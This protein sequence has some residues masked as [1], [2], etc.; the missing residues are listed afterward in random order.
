MKWA[1]RNDEHIPIRLRPSWQAERD[2]PWGALV[3]IAV[4]FLMVLAMFWI[5]ENAR[6]LGAWFERI[7]EAL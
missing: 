6:V 1:S 7:L 2:T 3:G 4:I 5:G